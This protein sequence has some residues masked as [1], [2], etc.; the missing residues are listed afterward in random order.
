MAIATLNTG[1][2]SASMG[3]GFRDC[4][5]IILINLVS[6]LLPAWNATFGLTGLRMTTFSRYS[7]GY[8][9][10]L[11]VVVFSM[12]STT[13]WNAINSISGAS[14]LY[15]VSDGKCP[16]WVGTSAKHLDGNAIRSSTGGNGVAAAFSTIAIIS[17]F[18]V[19]WINC[20]ADYNVKIPVNTPRWKIFVATYIGIT[21]PTVLVQTLGAALFTGTVVNP[22]WKA[23]YHK[24]GVGGPLKLALAPAGGFG[25]FLLVITALSSIPNFGPWALRIPRITFVTFGFVA[26][27]TASC[28]A[29]AFFED[30]LLTFL[31]II[32]YWTIVHLVVI[33]EEHVIFRRSS[34]SSYDW[35]A[36]ARHD[37]LPFGWGAIAAFAFGFAGAALGMTVSWYTGPI[38]GTIGA[39]VGN[40]GHELTALFCGV[41]FPVF[42]WLEKRY[43]GR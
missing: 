40:V 1:M 7:F 42:K 37:L 27:I 32:G 4:F 38:A 18:A 15:A 31:S 29:A 41:S 28:C 14:A 16:Q 8:W 43:S 9:G 11:L 3:L 6:C 12:I 34:W 5:A 13:G 35:D 22:A 26:A 36:W 33:I 17:S 10:N 39:K 30:T 23:A 25:N 2:A 20:A 19:S 24:A 21:V